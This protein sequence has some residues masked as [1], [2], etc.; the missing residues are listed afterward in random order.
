MSAR[1]KAGHCYRVEL[2]ARNAA[3]LAVLEMVC[4]RIDALMPMDEADIQTIR[5][6]IA[7]AKGLKIDRE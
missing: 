1:C 5:A 2:E 4:E 6:A 3:L 7:K